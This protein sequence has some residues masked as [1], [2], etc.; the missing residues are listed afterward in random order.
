MLEGGGEGWAV[1]DCE[2]K[3]ETSPREGWRRE[4][5]R[6]RPSLAQLYKGR[7]V[8]KAE[9]KSPSGMHNVLCY[10]NNL[11]SHLLSSDSAKQL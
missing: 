6:Q 7:F 1:P 2:Q 3:R 9:V 8:Q 4:G 10:R 5:D 11:S